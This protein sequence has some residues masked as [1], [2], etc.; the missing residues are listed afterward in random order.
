MKGKKID[1]NGMRFGSWLVL[2]YGAKDA[3]GNTKWDCVCDCGV[4]SSVRSAE[5]RNGN[6]TGCKKCQRDKVTTHGDYGTRLYNTWAQMK[7]RCFNI[8]A[9]SYKDYG[10]RGIT[11][12]DEWSSYPFF[13]DW[14]L[15]N[16]YTD[17]LTLD[18]IDNDG[19]YDPSNCRWST[20]KEQNRN[21]RGTIRMPDGTAAIV[22]AESNGVSR[23]TMYSRIKYGWCVEKAV[24]FPINYSNK[25]V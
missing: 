11:V 17:E 19:N 25:G 18:R 24:S 16:D 9:Q 13:R 8:N 10:G 15:S 4:T 1:L 12:C 14:A 22:V 23:M 7:S 21:K 5:L 6:S 20:M 2:G 3:Y